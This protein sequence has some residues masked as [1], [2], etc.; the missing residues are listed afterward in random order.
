MSL[1]SVDFQVLSSRSPE[2][3]EIIRRTALERRGVNPKP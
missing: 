2:I 3:T 1:H